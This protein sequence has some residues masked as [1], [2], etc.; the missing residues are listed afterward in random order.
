MVGPG[1]RGDDRSA[2]P[3]PVGDIG[4]ASRVTASG[5]T[6]LWFAVPSK[7]SR[8]A[9]AL[10]VRRPHPVVHPPRGLRPPGA[11]SVNFQACLPRPSAPLQ[12][13][14]R[15]PRV[16]SSGTTGSHEVSAPTAQPKSDEPPLPEHPTP[17]PVASLPFLPAPTP[18]SRRHLP[19]VFQPGAP[20]GFLSLRAFPNS[21]RRASRPAPPFLRL[22]R[23][24]SASGPGGPAASSRESTFR[25]AA[26]GRTGGRAQ[27]A[28]ACLFP[29][30]CKSDRPSEWG[31]EVPS[32]QGVHPAAGGK[33]AAM[34]PWP[35][36]SS[37]SPRRSLLPGAFPF[38]ASA[39]SGA[40]TALRP[41]ARA[42]AS[43]PGSS[44]RTP[45]LSP[46]CRGSPASASSPVLQ[47]QAL[48]G[49][50]PCTT[51][52]QR[53]GKSAGLFRGCRPLRGFPPRPVDSPVA[54]FLGGCRSGRPTPFPSPVA[55]LT[56]AG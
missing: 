29:G 21:D 47:G 23:P 10:L 42:L 25:L 18:S 56:W 41:S 32:L 33:S 39:F 9:I 7:T 31:S 36:A 50:F 16:P 28:A 44:P 37:C 27:G 19:G 46:G 43:P 6:L 15:I 2:S 17:G 55:S 12:S 1:N 20:S 5:A 38:P 48:P 49:S 35:P 26:S 24:R 34:S 40:A 53:T 51:E 13:H 45:P 4:F 52:F 11:G 54:R 22:G 30:G 14:P 8:R 3:E